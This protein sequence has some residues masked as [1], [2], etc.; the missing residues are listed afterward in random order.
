[1][2]NIKGQTSNV[3]Y[4]DGKNEKVYPSLYISEDAIPEIDNWKV[5]EEY[6]LKIK[7]KMTS[8]D[9]YESGRHTS[10]RLEII[11]YEDLTVEVDDPSIPKPGS[12]YGFNPTK[13]K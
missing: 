2:K 3:L 1:M 4:E 8:K 6:E 13:N 11:A 12:I 9:E 10:A 7:V 5:G